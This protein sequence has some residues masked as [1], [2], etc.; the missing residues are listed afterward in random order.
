[1]AKRGS[2]SKSFFSR[3]FTRVSPSETMKGSF[4]LQVGFIILIVVCVIGAL[5]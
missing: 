1:M 4:K 3:I 2:Q 5:V